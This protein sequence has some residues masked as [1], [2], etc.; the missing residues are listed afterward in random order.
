ML[1]LLALD[2]DAPRPQERRMAMKRW[3][4]TLL[5]SVLGGGLVLLSAGCVSERTSAQYRRDATRHEQLAA[6][7]RLRGESERAGEEERLARGARQRADQKEA[8]ELYFQDL[9]APEVSPHSVP[10]PS[11]VPP[12]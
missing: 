12:P 5:G 10:A 3:H 2:E 11:N 4:L 1:R 7:A 6:D 8:S 9:R